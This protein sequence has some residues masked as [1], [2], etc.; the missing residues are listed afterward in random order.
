MLRKKQTWQSSSP[1]SDP[2]GVRS[3]GAVQICLRGHVQSSDGKRI[4]SLASYGLAPDQPMACGPSDVLENPGEWTAGSKT[5]S[6]KLNGHLWDSNMFDRSSIILSAQYVQAVRM[7]GAG[8]EGGIR[9]PD[10]GFG[11]YNGLANLVRTAP[12][13]R[14][15]S[16]SLSIGLAVRAELCLLATNMHHIM[17]QRVRRFLTVAYPSV[18]LRCGDHPRR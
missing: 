17:H 18:T 1:A 12:V 9:T 8:G 6:Q 4:S 14:N 10:T 13:A 5:H 16:F 11:P 15:Q 2:S 7:L 3:F